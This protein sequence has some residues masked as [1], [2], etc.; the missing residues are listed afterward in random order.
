MKNI[1][2]ISVAV[3]DLYK[4]IRKIQYDAKK[5]L[6]KSSRTLV[7]KIPD[8]P[9]PNAKRKNITKASLKVFRGIQF[10]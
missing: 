5:Y 10:A 1:N 6:A 3:I 4:K 7:L 8:S 2:K 9:S